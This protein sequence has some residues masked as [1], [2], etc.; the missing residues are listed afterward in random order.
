[1]LE[2]SSQIASRRVEKGGMSSVRH[3][4]ARFSRHRSSLQDRTDHGRRPVSMA[5]ARSALLPLL[6]DHGAMVEL[7]ALLHRSGIARTS[8][9]RHTDHDVLRA[10]ALLLSREPP[11][12]ALPPASVSAVLYARPDQGSLHHREP[13]RFSSP[14]AAKA[15]LQNLLKADRAGL[16]VVIW[17]VKAREGTAVARP[18]QKS[19]DGDIRRLAT[20]L[21]R[22][23]LAVAPDAADDRVLHFFWRREVEVAGGGAAPAAEAPTPR[24]QAAP[25]LVTAAEFPPLPI[26]SGNAPATCDCMRGAANAGAPFVA[27]A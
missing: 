22:R 26:P 24:R 27:A 3:I 5:K 18:V 20:L 1:M 6:H 25:P 21:H 7:R 2:F 13:I 23:E 12:P 9:S 11:P 8:L 15:F 10:A 16:D 17:E 14:E 19:D 4:L